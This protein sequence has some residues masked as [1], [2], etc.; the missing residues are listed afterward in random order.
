[1]KKNYR[2]D[3]LT[4]P[5]IRKMAENNAI[6]I[7]PIGSVEQH[8]PHLPVGCDYLMATNVSEK[9]AEKLNEIGKP[10][11]VAPSLSVCNSTHHMSFAGSMTL[12]VSTYMALLRDYCV[13]IAKHGFKKI[14]IVNGHGGNTAPTEAALIDINEE[15]GFPV[16]FTGYW[17]SDDKAQT[18][19][20]ETQSGMIHACESETSMVLSYDETLVDPVYKQTKGNPGYPLEVENNGILH[21]FHRMEIHTENGVMGNSFMA[22]KEKG[23]KMTERFVDGFVKIFSDD[24]IWNQPV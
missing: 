20:L 1:M 13:S 11:L 18:E 2:W 22:S 4:S 12:R 9:I 10:C 23:D 19:I 24:R 14:V 7:L 8:G 21:T 16:Y 3:N 5:E 15:L 6:V 17:M